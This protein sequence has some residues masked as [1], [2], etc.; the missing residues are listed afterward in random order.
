[1]EHNKYT[2]DNSIDNNYI[3]PHLRSE[4]A[5]RG[6]PS[7][8]AYLSIIFYLILIILYLW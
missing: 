6:K 1:M 5:N 2:V 8:S 3:E 4:L 7:T